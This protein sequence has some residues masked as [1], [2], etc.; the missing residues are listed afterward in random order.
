MRYIPHT[1]R[2]IQ[3]MLARVGVTEIS[4]LFDS[5]PRALRLEKPLALPEGLAEA[6]LVADAYRRE[7]ASGPRCY[8]IGPLATLVQQTL[9]SPIPRTKS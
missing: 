1:E 5:I 6:E 9:V 3:E 7:T 4:N 8:T 2:D